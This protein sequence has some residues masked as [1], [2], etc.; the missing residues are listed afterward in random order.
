MRVSRLLP[1][2][3]ALL[4]TQHAS[5]Y[6]IDVLPPGALL[7]PP[8]YGVATFDD[9]TAEP[10]GSTAPF[11]TFSEGGATFSGD[12][13]VMNNYGGGS[14][15]LYA[16]PYGD[17]TNYMAV[18]GGHSETIAYAAARTDFGLYWGSVDAYN[19]LQFF[20]AGTLVAVV[21]GADVGPPL[22][23][24]GGQTDY[25][26]NGYVL[27]TGLPAFDTVVVSSSQNSFEFDNVTIAAAPELSTWAMLGI[28]LLG[29]ASAATRRGRKDRLAPAL[30]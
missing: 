1:L 11:G 30:E 24:S 27:L 21:G 8:E 12:G 15:G 17:P 3:A 20:S 10:Y 14:L 22:Q 4:L 19:A 28:G 29:L 9:L 2:A 16:T 6:T 13:V 25:S 5:A 7:P 26:S 23:A 18:L